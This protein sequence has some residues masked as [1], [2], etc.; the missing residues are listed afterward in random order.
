MNQPA[1]L[2]TQLP[3]DIR[4]ALAR[5]AQTPV[6]PQDPNARVK[7]IEKVMQ[8]ARSTHPQLFRRDE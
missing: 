7:A 4:V 2:S 6:T 3:F 8:R 5:A 1:P